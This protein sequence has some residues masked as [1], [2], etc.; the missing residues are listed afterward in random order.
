MEKWTNKWR[1]AHHYD[2]GGVLGRY[3]ETV[4]PPEVCQTAFATARFVIQGPESVG[5]DA[6]NWGEW[7]RTIVQTHGETPGIN[8]AWQDRKGGWISGDS[9]E[10]A[11]SILDCFDLDLTD[12]FRF[13]GDPEPGKI[14]AIDLV[15]VLEAIKPDFIREYNDVVAAA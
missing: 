5:R 4:L 3:L 10:A 6:K 15:D 8:H 9:R 12:I 11:N 1:K 7:V 13:F 2:V 14:Y